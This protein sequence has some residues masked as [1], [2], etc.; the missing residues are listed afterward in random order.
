MEK[1][2]DSPP[3]L[4][5]H[6]PCG[7]SSLGRLIACPA[8][9]RLS[10][11]EP[12]IAS[13][14]AKEGSAL[15]DLFYSFHK[16]GY[17]SKNVTDEQRELVLD[18]EKFFENTIAGREI[19]KEFVEERVELIDED[20]HV[21]NYGRVDLVTVTPDCVYVFDWKFGRLIHRHSLVLQLA[22]YA[23][24]AVQTLLADR[25]DSGL[26]LE[27]HAYFPRLARNFLW[28]SRDIESE[29]ES[30]REKVWSIIARAEED[31]SPAVPGPWCDSCN[32]LFRCKAVK[33]QA[34]SLKTIEETNWLQRPE[35]IAKLYDC[36]TLAVKQFEAL[37]ARIREIL[38]DQPNALP[39]LELQE[40]NGRRRVT[41]IEALKRNLIESKLFSET[42]FDSLVEKI[43][44]PVALEESYLQRNYKGRGGG[45][46]TKKDLRK[47]LE[48][49][50]GEAI[51]Q[52]KEK[53]LRRTSDG[54][55]Q[56]Q[57]SI[58]VAEGSNE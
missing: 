25:L 17:S 37:K 24:A 33:N 18:C 57:R 21:I 40:V 41:D 34:E 22:N 52:S 1:Q 45:L 30:V 58:V 23:V 31:K 46:P 2:I 15:H 6:D 16:H 10:W 42:Q 51:Y 55:D 53:R 8:S 7:P 43:V 12:Q 19:L 28:H 14:Y 3:D 48:I 32:H 44:R 47:K 39:G 27:A 11:N 4:P 20:N 9:Y 36:G 13:D 26:R 5:E 29:I 54:V 56:A 38:A 50:A 49:A 35:T